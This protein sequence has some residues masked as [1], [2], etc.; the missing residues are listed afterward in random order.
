M[1]T[2]QYVDENTNSSGIDWNSTLGKLE[3]A[4]IG[5]GVAVLNKELDT[6]VI[7]SGNSV[8]VPASNVSGFITGNMTLWLIIGVIVVVFMFHKR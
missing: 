6:N 1:F 5:A 8:N 7:K 3:D 4:T 2:E